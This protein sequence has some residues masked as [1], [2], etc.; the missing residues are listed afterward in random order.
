MPL[1]LAFDHL[2]DL[3]GKRNAD[4]YEAVNGQLMRQP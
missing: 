1:E 2:I 3:V 4:F